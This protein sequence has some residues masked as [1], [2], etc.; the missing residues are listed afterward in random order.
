[1][2]KRVAYIKRRL[3]GRQKWDLFPQ[4]SDQQLL[5]RQEQAHYTLLIGFGSFLIQ[6]GAREIVDGLSKPSWGFYVATGI[7]LYFVYLCFSLFRLRWALEAFEQFG[8]QSITDLE[9]E[10]QSTSSEK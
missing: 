10:I 5:R 7:F 1:M 2:S 6:F 9:G 3:K 4:D 8:P